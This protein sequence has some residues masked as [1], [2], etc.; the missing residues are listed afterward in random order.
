MTLSGLAVPLTASWLKV[1]TLVILVCVVF[2]ITPYRASPYTF[3]NLTLFDPMLRELSV[4]GKIL[5]EKVDTPATLTLSKFVC[6]STSKSPLA[7]IL[8]EKVVTHH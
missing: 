8:L 5:P 7:S 2:W 3:A 1:P 4:P 6:P